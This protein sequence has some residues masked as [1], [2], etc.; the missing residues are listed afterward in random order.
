MWL[1]SAHAQVQPC[2]FLG[3]GTIQ[4]HST[5]S[6]DEQRLDMQFSLLA[7]LKNELACPCTV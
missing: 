5:L 1:F 4:G 3:V 2:C 7:M 6:E